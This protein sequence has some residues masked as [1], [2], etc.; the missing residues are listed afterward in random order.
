[1]SPIPGS[2]PEPLFPRAF[3]AVRPRSVRRG[4]SLVE[5]ALIVPVM[6]IILMLAIDFG[7]LFFSYVQLTNA[8]R[9]GANYGILH[10]E[11]T[12][13][14]Q[15]RALQETNAQSQAG[16]SGSTTV[17]VSC[18]PGSCAAAATS[19]PTGP[20]NTVTV[21]VSRTFSFLTPVLGS[22]TSIPLRV[23]ATSVAIGSAGTAPTPPPCRN[24]P[25]VL[26]MTSAAAT[27]AI[28]SA[29]LVPNPQDDLTNGTKDK[30]QSQAPTAG[31]C[32]NATTTVVTFHYRP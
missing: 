24:V 29:G 4:Q 1:M 30:V 19:S 26:N 5:F 32:A 23:S 13:G 22:L 18:A 10:P 6:L 21:N 16:E 31:T 27:S 7:R 3:G 14:I 12:S 20:Q 28:Q 8:A 17:A 9:E 15:A 11:D 25:N 2:K